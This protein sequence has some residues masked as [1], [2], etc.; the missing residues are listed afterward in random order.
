MHREVRGSVNKIP[1]RMDDIF[2][3]P[4]SSIEPFAVAYL[5]F[6]VT[7]ANAFYTE[8]DKYYIANFESIC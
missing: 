5:D 1:R 3:D 6:L 7:L 2:V 4:V 8:S